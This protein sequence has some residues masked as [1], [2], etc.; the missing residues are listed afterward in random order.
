M[1]AA[2]GQRGRDGGG[3]RRS[4][5]DVI[6]SQIRRKRSASDRKPLGRFLSRTSERTAIPEDAEPENRGQS[7]GAAAPVES[8]RD[9]GWGRVRVFLQRLG[10][11]ADS[12]SLS[13]AHCDL[14]ATDLLEL[15]SLLQFLPQ[16]EEMDVS[17]NELIGGGLTTLTS[18]LQHVGGIRT[19]KLC[20]CRLDADDV[21]ALGEALPSVPVLEILDLSWN[22]SVGGTL[23][24]L[25]G[26]LQPSVREL[27]L[28]A[29]QLTA[30]DAAALGGLVAV[31]PKLCV[32]DVSCNPRLTQEVDAGGFGQLAASLSHAVSLIVL[33]L[34]ACGL[35]PDDL[36]A[37]GASLRCLPSVRQLD[38]SCNRSVAGGLSGLA[39]HLAHMAHLESLDLHLCRL[40]R[41][42][43]EA[44]IQ[45]LPSLTALTAL[46]VSS[47]KEAGGAVHQLVSV[48]PLTQ[49]RRLPMSSCRLTEES[50]TALAL[51]APY[52]RSLDV[53]WCK[54]VG[55]RLPLLMDALQPSVVLELRLSSCGL[56]TDDLRHL[57]DVCR[58][59]SLSS[60]RVLDLS[61]NGSVGDAAWAALF[62]AGGLGSLEEADLSLRPLTSAPCSAWLPALL[63]ALPRMPALARLA[64]Q[65]W[66]AGPQEEQQLRFSVKNRNIR[67]DWDPD[68]SD[69]KTS[70]QEESQAEE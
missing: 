11:K 10:K 58:R 66:S 33:R 63:G 24:S 15:A 64:M 50:F 59:G 9:A 34:Q 4:P 46:D 37:L 38:L 32:L 67:L 60:L 44:L 22:S 13:L 2:E 7:P 45:V 47:N 3:Q 61:Y 5:L 52:L 57:A 29:C 25:L 40:R 23:Q 18:H 39:S 30:A 53:S 48:L 49:M 19:L 41:A 69:W 65:R 1:E 20:S 62:A 35:K 43:L 8:Q 16:L 36:E 42:D 70:S 14:T 54:V 17:W 27:H 51:V 56:T 28:V 6:M 26:K 31:L 55:G 21:A 68:G 12:R